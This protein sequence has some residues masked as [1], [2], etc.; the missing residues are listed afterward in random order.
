MPTLSLN[1]EPI[2]GSAITVVLIAGIKTRPIWLTSTDVNRSHEVTSIAKRLLG[3]SIK[4]R[5]E[6]TTTS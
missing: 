5:S 1:S 6:P 2:T 4:P 3:V